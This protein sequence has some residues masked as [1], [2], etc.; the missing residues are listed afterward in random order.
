M[1]Q[2]IAETDFDILYLGFAI[3]AGF[4]MLRKGRNTLVRKAGSMSALLGAGDA[5]HLIPR[6]Y[7]LWTLAWRQMQCH[8]AW[9]NLLP[10][11]P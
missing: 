8:W 1:P 10:P 9:A 2:A 7:A 6:T 5:F 3:F 4:T 11:L